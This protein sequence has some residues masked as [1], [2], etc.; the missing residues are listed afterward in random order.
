MARLDIDV[1]VNGASQVSALDGQLKK[2]ERTTKNLKNAL[3][4]ATIVAGAFTAAM[5]AIGAVGFKFNQQMEESKAGIIALSV[6]T[7]DKAIP[8]LE[9]Y[10]IAQREALVTTEELRAEIEEW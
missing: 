10:N 8:V 2:T 7:Q 5:A 1:S 9:R 4:A 6:A 3:G